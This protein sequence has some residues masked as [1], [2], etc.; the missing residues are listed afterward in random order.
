MDRPLAKLYV[1]ILISVALAILAVPAVVG[2]MSAWAADAATAAK[3]AAFKAAGEDQQPPAD[4]KGSVVFIMDDGYETQYTRGYEI[5]KRSGMSAAISVIPAA[6]GDAG[7]MDYKQLAGMYMDGW[8]M[9]NHTYNHIDL[10]GLGKEE[11]A[12]Q[13][14]RGMAWLR[15]RQLL[16]G[17]DILIFPGGEHNEQTIEAMKETGTAAARSLKSLWM[18][19]L[20]CTLE[21]AEICNI[22]STLPLKNIEAAIDKAANNKSAVILVLHKIEPITD[23]SQ[24]QTDEATLQAIV[25]YI[26]GREDELS[27]VTPSEL[28]Q[29]RK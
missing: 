9:L 11:Q 4:K 27:V 28:L 2:R 7:Y 1:V 3:L 14:S 8:D 29:S 26:E 12:S 5:L 15:G 16:R 10:T 25:D 17:S 24:M 18:T 13:I 22:I 19:T 23:D 20:D 21:D 6:V